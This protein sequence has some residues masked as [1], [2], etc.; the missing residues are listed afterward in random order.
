MQHLEAQQQVSPVSPAEYDEVMK[1]WEASVRA[2]HHYLKEKDLQFYKPLVRNQYL[3][4]VK[5]TCIRHNDGR[6]AGFMGT[7][8]KNL[9]MLF[10]H[11]QSRGQG[12]GKKLLLHAINQLQVEKVDVNE[13]NEQAIGFY[14]RFGFRT[15][16][17]SDVDGTGRPY[18][19]LHMQLPF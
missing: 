18:P 5:L 8:K 4:A 11:P 17:R 9:E 15:V 10:I 12:I 6:I 14:E 13:Q 16:E 19:I 2:T 7:A 1:V 3:K